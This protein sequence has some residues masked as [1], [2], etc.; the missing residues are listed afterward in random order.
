MIDQLL[1]RD[2][3]DT[4]E[5]QDKFLKSYARH[6][7]ISK[8]AEEVDIDRSSHYVWYRSDRRGYKAKFDALKEEIDTLLED[9]AIELAT[10]QHSEGVY[11]MGNL[12]GTKRV[13]DSKVLIKLMECRMPEKYG[14]RETV[15]HEGSIDIVERLNRGRLR[16]LEEPEPPKEAA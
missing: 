10:G 6:G 4:A 14:K 15:T 3:W 2:S 1:P 5:K 8:A 13:F 9:T 11:N 7:R 12:V 16:L